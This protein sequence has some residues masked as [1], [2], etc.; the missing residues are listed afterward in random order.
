MRRRCLG[1]FYMPQPKTPDEVLK[2]QL[3]L[4]E[5]EKKMCKAIEKNDVHAA[6]DFANFADMVDSGAL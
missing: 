3:R 6:M 4:A 1:V 2:K 5:I